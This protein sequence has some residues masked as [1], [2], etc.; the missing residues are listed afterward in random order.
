[1]LGQED[2]AEYE[3]AG[4][5]C[6]KLPSLGRSAARCR[7]RPAVSFIDTARACPSNGIE[8]GCTG[9]ASK[10]KRCNYKDRWI[11]QAVKEGGL[12]ENGT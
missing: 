3:T 6:V 8:S 12:G 5:F 11:K 1:M 9:D 4:S 10:N 2:P 7:S